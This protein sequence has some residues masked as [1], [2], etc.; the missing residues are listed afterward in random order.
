MPGWKEPSNKILIA[1]DPVV[2]E[3]H[4][5]SS[6][7]ILPG[8]LVYLSGTNTIDEGGEDEGSQNMGIGFAGYEQ[9]SDHYKPDDIETAYSDGAMIPVLIGPCVLLAIV[10]GATTT[11]QANDALTGSGAGDGALLSGTIGTDHIYAIALEAETTE[12]LSPVIVL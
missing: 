1:G 5:G 9:A 6:G 10:D 12:V 2:M 11:T 8:D 3:F 7:A 4:D